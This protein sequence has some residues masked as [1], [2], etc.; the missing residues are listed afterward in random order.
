MPDLQEFDLRYRRRVLAFHAYVNTDREPRSVAH[1]IVRSTRGT[2]LEAM[3]CWIGGWDDGSTVWSDTWR[4]HNSTP[5]A[6]LRY[7]GTLCAVNVYINTDRE[8]YHIQKKILRI[9]RGPRLDA[10]VVWS[11]VYEGDNGQKVWTEIQKVAVKVHADP[12]A[13]PVDLGQ[14]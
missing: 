6:E 1:E 12:R 4:A 10:C 3:A 11:E 7:S 14:R 5:V 13:Y 2:Q 9:A 8:P